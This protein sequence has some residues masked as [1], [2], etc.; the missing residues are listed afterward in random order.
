MSIS[1][2]GFTVSSSNDQ[3]PGQ[4]DFGALQFGIRG[5]VFKPSVVASTSRVESV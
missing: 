1:H 2:S 4:L 3:S 5:L